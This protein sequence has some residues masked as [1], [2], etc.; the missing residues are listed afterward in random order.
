MTVVQCRAS[1][2]KRWIWRRKM[3]AFRTS[4][5]EGASWDTVV[6]TVVVALEMV[7]GLVSVLLE[8]V[9]A[10]AAV[11]MPANASRSPQARIERRNAFPLKVDCKSEAERAG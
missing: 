11:A 3:A 10:A 6:A 7:I 5:G 4:Q 1:A 2:R 8:A 9:A